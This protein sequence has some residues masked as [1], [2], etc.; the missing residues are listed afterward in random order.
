MQLAAI[1]MYRSTV[2][3]TDFTVLG[4]Y[5]RIFYITRLHPNPKGLYAL[6]FSYTIPIL[7]ETVYAYGQHIAF[8]KKIWMNQPF[9]GSVQN[10]MKLSLKYSKGSFP[11]P[12]LNFNTR[13]THL[14]IS[15]LEGY[16]F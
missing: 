11:N 15:S 9:N 14:Y 4:D 10:I 2:H 7:T 13:S 6:S 8:F 5:T 12:F 3:W 1:Y 16:H